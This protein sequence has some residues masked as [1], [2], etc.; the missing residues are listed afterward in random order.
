MLEIITVLCTL[1]VK[2]RKPVE[3]DTTIVNVYML[4]ILN[5]YVYILVFQHSFYF[6]GVC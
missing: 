4:C 3:Q 2:G 5:I 1:A 6:L